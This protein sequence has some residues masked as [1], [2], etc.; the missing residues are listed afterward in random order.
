M[1]KKKLTYTNFYYYLLLTLPLLVIY[2]VF[3]IIPVVQSMLY[4]FTNFNGLNLF[5]DFVGLKNYKVMLGDV[6]FRKSVV[7]TFVIAIGV[8]ILQNVLAMFISLGLN[9]KFKFQG[10]VRVLVFT[11]CMF[12]PVV[13][14]YIWQFIFSPD[15]LVNKL[16]GLDKVWL[17]D[18]K[19]A[20][21]II[22][23]A[24]TWIWLGYTATIF[25]A[26]LQ[27]ISGE[28]KEAAAVDG[29]H[30]WNLF[31]YITLPLMAPS[32]TINVSLAFTGSLKMFDL[33]YAMTGGGPSGATEVMG[34][35]IM[36]KMGASL[37]GYASCLTV[38]MMILIVVFGRVLTN[39]LQKREEE[40]RG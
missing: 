2:I 7:N 27:T 19:L 35:Y 16:F 32:I 15:G 17:A 29:C 9:L 18:S 28:I 21:W 10:M 24:H 25:L 14:A 37:Y 26:N 39:I 6:A 23:I 11:P 1:K 36:K 31:R 38:I 40:V 33:V 12:A 3:F 30:G 5:P 34:T 8:T 22:V 13:V 4:S 20:I